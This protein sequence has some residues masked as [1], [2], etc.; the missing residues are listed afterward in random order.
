MACNRPGAVNG[1]KALL[2][3]MHSAKLKAHACN[4]ATM[5]LWIVFWRTAACKVT[6]PQNFAVPTLRLPSI[7]G[8]GPDNFSL[9]PATVEPFE[10]YE[11]IITLLYRALPHLKAP[12]CKHT[13]ATKDR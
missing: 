1:V 5:A 6:H 7:F 8:C 4:R 3:A 10:I 11:G 2:A 13:A 12:Q 9:L